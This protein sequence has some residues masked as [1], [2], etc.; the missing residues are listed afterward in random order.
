[1]IM[2]SLLAEWPMSYRVRI[3]QSKSAE[4]RHAAPQQV[5]VLCDA[6]SKVSLQMMYA[7]PSP[8]GP[9]YRA[10]VRFEAFSVCN[11]M[12]NG[13]AVRLAA[14]TG[15]ERTGNLIDLN[16]VHLLLWSD[17]SQSGKSLPDFSAAL[18]IPDLAALILSAYV[19]DERSPT[20]QMD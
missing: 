8:P 18:A 13:H 10:S 7:A 4:R 17:R 20:T 11:G 16:L 19:A 5:V 14:S 9:N 1:M 12:P 6:V 2:G 15:N 3:S